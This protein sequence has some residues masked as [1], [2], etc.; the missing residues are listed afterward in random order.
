MKNYRLG[1]LRQW[2]LVIVTL[3]MIL[4]FIPLTTWSA[5]MIKLDAQA[6]MANTVKTASQVFRGTVSAVV[7]PQM[8]IQVSQYFKGNGPNT[9]TITEVDETCEQSITVGQEAIFVVKFNTHQ[10]V[11]AVITSQE[12][13]LI[14]PVSPEIIAATDCIATYD[15]Q[16]GKVHI[17]CLA[18][19]Q[20]IEDIYSVNL[21]LESNEPLLLSVDS[22]VPPQTQQ[23]VHVKQI[24]I[25]TRQ[26][27]PIQVE[28]FVKGELSDTC[29]KLAP[30]QV[31]RQDNTFN[32]T[33]TTITNSPPPGLDCSSM[34]IPF[35]EII[36]LEVTGLADDTYIVNVNDQSDIFQLD[37]DNILFQA[38]IEQVEV[39]II[40]SFPVQVNIKVD[41][42]F[43]HGCQQIEQIEVTRTN[44]IFMVTMTT[45]PPLPPGI[46]CTT[47]L[48]PFEEII[49][50]DV[51][52]LT[53]G[54]YTVDVNGIRKQFELMKDNVVISN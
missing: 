31:I 54:V 52:G 8:V 19:N 44:N 9:I 2:F 14:Q 39:Q 50:L 11:P 18:V 23:P 38:F 51:L 53:E 21:S 16:Q 12:L 13:I 46:T 45:T 40:E 25:K 5:C 29:Q 35:E 1:Y 43:L 20:G 32:I 6:G 27:L 4:N 47:V 17:P 22:V 41:G 10:S 37:R 49:A 7:L 24:D 42:Q 15:L 3:G 28:V 30:L 33:I 26:Y 34:L 36:P 48:N